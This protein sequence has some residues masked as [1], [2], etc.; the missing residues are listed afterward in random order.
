MYSNVYECDN[1]Q[2]I[3]NDDVCDG[4][5]DC[6]DGSDEDGCAGAGGRAKASQF[7]R[8]PTTAVVFL[9]A[10]FSNL[11]FTGGMYTYSSVFVH[12][13]SAPIYNISFF[14]CVVCVPSLTHATVCIS[15]LGY[16]YYQYE[17]D[18]GECILDDNV[19]DGTEDCY[20]GSDEDG[21]A[22]AGGRAKYCVASQFLRAPTTAVVFLGA[23]FSSLV[24]TG[25]MYTY[26]SV[27]VYFP[28]APIYN[29]S[30]FLCVVCVPSLTHATSRLLLQLSVRVRQW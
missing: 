25:G 1:G 14:L 12:F 9:G 13:P 17:C 21:C 19:C 29:I 5:E 7:L 4:T 3:S 23:L 26:S 24:F 27:F 28:S 22:G 16:C 8:A 6:Y 11:V 15:S 30:F 18:S 2:C 10:L 20:D